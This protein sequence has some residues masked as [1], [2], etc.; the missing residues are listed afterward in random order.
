MVLAAKAVNSR[1]QA[2][3]FRMIRMRGEDGLQMVRRLAHAA[4]FEGLCG[5]YDVVDRGPLKSCKAG[6]ARQSVDG[7]TPLLDAISMIDSRT[8]PS[9]RSHANRA[10]PSLLCG[11]CTRARAIEICVAA[12]ARAIRWLRSSSR[13]AHLTAAAVSQAAC[14]ADRQPRVAPAM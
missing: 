3:H 5:R 13:G 12:K 4:S 2:Q 7:Q 9:L 14:L 10:Q 11:V 1:E 6:P 8:E